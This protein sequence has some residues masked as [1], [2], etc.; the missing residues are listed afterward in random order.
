MTTMISEVYAAFLSI[1]VS[2]D[3]AQKAAEALSNESAASNS[4]IQNLEKEVVS[5]RTDLQKDIA[6]VKTDIAVMKWML[7]VVMAGVAAQI[8]KTFFV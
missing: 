2:P 8:I 5:V 4:D 1:G 7:G 3:I 6:G